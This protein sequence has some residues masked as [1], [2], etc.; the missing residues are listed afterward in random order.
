MKAIVGLVIAI[1]YPI[2][3]I[4]VW[5]WVAGFVGWPT[6]ILITIVSLLIG[7]AVMVSAGGAAARSLVQSLRANTVPS[8]EA[9]RHGL[10]FLAGVLIAIPGLITTALGVV[11]LT[12]LVAGLAQRLLARRT[13]NWLRKRGFSAVTVTD[14]Q[15]RKG[16]RIKPGD[17]VEGEI[18]EP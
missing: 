9:A 8:T 5:R 11:L 1:G 13:E 15:G 2:A 7:I 17:I 10:R 4:L 14:D 16:T 18:L 12:P 3:E 6:V